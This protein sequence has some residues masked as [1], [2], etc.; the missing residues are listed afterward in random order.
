MKT[1]NNNFQITTSRLTNITFAFFPIS[2]I[3]GNLIININLILFCCL[4][5]LHLKSQIFRKNFNTSI[6]VIF[7]FFGLIFFSTTLNLIRALYIDGF[8]NTDFDQFLK[9][10]FFFRFFLILIIVYFLSEI[11]ILKFKYFFLSAAFFPILISLDVIYQYVFGFNFIGLESIVSHNSSFFGT[12]LIAGGYIQNFSLFSIFFLLSMLK[13]NNIKFTL[14]VI[15]IFILA[16]GILLSGNRMPF[17]LFLFGLFLIFFINK[18]LR[19]VI[20]TSLVFLLVFFWS[21]STFDKQV[22]S[23]FKS[24]YGH[25]KNI[26]TYITGTSGKNESEIVLNKEEK[27]LESDF[28]LFWV[29]GNESHG[30][31]KLFN[32]AIDTWKQ[33]ILF[34]NGIK[35][36]R[37]DCIKFQRHKEN[38]MCSTHPHNYYLEILTETGIAGLVTTIMLAAMFIIFIIKNRGLLRERNIENFILLASVISLI[39]EMFPIK[40]S[41]SIFTTYNA[42][43]I[44]LIASIILSFQR[45]IIT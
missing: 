29:M 10:I 16:T 40:S 31:I 32:T 4:G 33:N 13:N 21:I 39:L 6:K 11:N 2:F 19:K 9:S 23:N 15:F 36:F 42:T 12:E 26:L 1:F 3:L 5:I 14:I 25:A 41:G 24:Y 44:T 34:G 37:K 17:V 30:H 20:L 27:S 45:K 22:K 18:E 38:R 7:L 35:S 8:E 28:D 43:Y